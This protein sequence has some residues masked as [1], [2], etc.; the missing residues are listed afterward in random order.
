LFSWRTRQKN[1]NYVVVGVVVDKCGRLLQPRRQR[2]RRITNKT[3]ADRA[4]FAPVGD[5]YNAQR[6]YTRTGNHRVVVSGSFFRRFSLA[7][8][9]YRWQRV[10][11]KVCAW[12]CVGIISIT[13]P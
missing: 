9:Y 8:V 2:L 12:T 7:D 10:V 4:Q 6:G 1:V 3:L 5:H 11:E 13:L